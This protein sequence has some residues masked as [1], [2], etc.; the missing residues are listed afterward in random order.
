MSDMQ[1]MFFDKISDGQVE[2][3]CSFRCP[4]EEDLMS[5]KQRNSSSGNGIWILK[6]KEN[7]M[8]DANRVKFSKVLDNDLD[9]LPCVLY[10]PLSYFS[11]TRSR[12]T[13]G[14]RDRIDT[15]RNI[16]M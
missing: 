3:C 4:S 16:R 2:R 11:N 15:F 1:R 14:Y 6:S 8:M 5:G 7:N 13:P 12:Q 10:V 9:N